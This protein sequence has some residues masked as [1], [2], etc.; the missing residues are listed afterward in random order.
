[1]KNIDVRKQFKLFGAFAMNIKVTADYEVTVTLAQDVKKSQFFGLLTYMAVWIALFTTYKS[2]WGIATFPYGWFYLA[3]ACGYILVVVFQS[4][5][6]HRTRKFWL[7]VWSIIFGS[8]ILQVFG[9]L[10][11]LGYG[12]RGELATMV[13]EG[14]VFPRW[15]GGS[16]ILL[17][18]Y[19]LWTI[20][21][22]LSKYSSDINSVLTVIKVLGGIVMVFISV[23]LLYKWPN[24]MSII[25]PLTTP[26]YLMISMGYDEYYP[27]IAGL[28]LVFLVNVFEMDSAKQNVYWL[29]FLMAILSVFYIPFLAISMIVLA[30][31]YFSYSSMR[32]K[33]L[34]T[35]LS[36]FILSIFL[37]WPSG[38]GNYITSL[39]S[40]INTGN[41][42]L[43]FSRYKDQSASNNIFFKP[44][45]VTTWE[46]FSDLF[47]MFLWSGN[48][49]IGVLLG[50]GVY[51]LTKIGM[52]KKFI[53]SPHIPLLSALFIWQ[54]FYF[55]FMLPRLGPRTD[56]DLFFSFYICLAFVTGHILD[57]IKAQTHLGHKLD[58]IVIPAVMANAVVTLFFLVIVGIPKII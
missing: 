34:L 3:V 20:I 50:T 18:I 39:I 45:N 8:I 17:Y 55:V 25:L 31:Y 27:F 4:I 51:Y 30:Y 57:F 54:L 43:L 12:D 5:S 53:T 6:E 7:I 29:G 1:M 41:M 40:K 21:P 9:L 52:L 42:L 19:K 24:R 33:L 44:Q 49:V 22:G 37:F 26:V 28:F 32:Q 36:V 38:Q 2:F 23:S 16:A 11:L 48:M 46:H 35:F 56:I 14:V 13:M 58:D 10:N 15:L 47:Y